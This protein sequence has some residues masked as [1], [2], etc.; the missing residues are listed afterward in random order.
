MHSLL[1]L[2][3]PTALC[4]PIKKKRV[5]NFPAT[6]AQLVH[7]ALAS[8]HLEMIVAI[9]LGAN[10]HNLYKIYMIS[11]IIVH[12]DQ[13]LEGAEECQHRQLAPYPPTSN[14]Q[15]LTQQ[16]LML[17]LP[18]AEPSVCGAIANVRRSDHVNP[19]SYTSIVHAGYHLVRIMGVIGR[20]L[21][22]AN[23]HFLSGLQQSW[24]FIL[25]CNLFLGMS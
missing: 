23:K 24:I 5:V 16:V 6:V 15:D 9:F 13:P 14:C 12:F 10:A 7:K 18:N 2:S 1:K 4:R 3:G 17:H 8:N 25:I 21:W 19:A 22:S 11:L 20:P